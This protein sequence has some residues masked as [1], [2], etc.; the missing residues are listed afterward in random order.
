M[1]QRRDPNGFDIVRLFTAYGRWALLGAALGGFIGLALGGPGPPHKAVNGVAPAPE[2]SD[3]VSHG[4]IEMIL[5]GLVG[6]L[7]FA[8]VAKFVKDKRRTR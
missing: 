1:R 2:W 3:Y 7:V 4:W 5:G 8:V 6:A